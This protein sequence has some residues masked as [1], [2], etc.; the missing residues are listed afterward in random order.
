[1]SEPRKFSLVKPTVTT[2]FHI[3]FAWWRNHDNN[4]RVFLHSILC[5]EHQAA[6]THLKDN[7]EIDWIDPETAEVHKVDG[8]Q[9]VLI[10]HCAKQDTFLTSYTTL[11]DAVFRALVAN[12]NQP[13]TP[14]EL[15]DRIHK[16]ADTILKTL[17]GPTVYKGIRPR[18]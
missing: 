11:V 1:M 4:W 5:Q 17:A 6:F 14:I 13:L 12:G 2:P 3:D 15:S 10:T 16:P 7:I 8:L 9:Q 18:H